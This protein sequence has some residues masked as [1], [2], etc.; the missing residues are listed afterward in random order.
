MNDGEEKEETGMQKPQQPDRDRDKK[1][2]AARNPGNEKNPG[3]TRQPRHQEE[4][5]EEDF[6]QGSESERQGR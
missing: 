3:S 6:G 2:G 5:E 1:A 4:D